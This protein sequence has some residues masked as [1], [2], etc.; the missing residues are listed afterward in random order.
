[1]KPE[2]SNIS[3][4]KFL[5]KLGT[6]EEVYILAIGSY[7]YRQGHLTLYNMTLKIVLQQKVNKQHCF[8][9]T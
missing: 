9:Y 4:K 8:Q 5:S 1:M 3:F 7:M 2:H 6:T